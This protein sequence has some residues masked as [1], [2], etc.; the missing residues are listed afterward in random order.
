MQRLGQFGLRKA[1]YK[2]LL[3]TDLVEYVLGLPVYSLMH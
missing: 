3:F 1:F 2:S